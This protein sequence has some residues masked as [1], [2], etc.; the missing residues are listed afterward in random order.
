MIK[1]INAFPT[2]MTVSSVLVSYY[3]AVR[4][5][6]IIRKLL[7]EFLNTHITESMGSLVYEFSIRVGREVEN[8]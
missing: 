2:V 5:D 6:Q 7:I 8:G 4:T 3:R 1:A